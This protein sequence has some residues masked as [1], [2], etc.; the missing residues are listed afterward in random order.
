[1][2]KHPFLLITL[3]ILSTTGSVLAESMEGDRFFIV[4]S[5]NPCNGSISELGKYESCLTL[6]QF[7]S[8]F[9]SH[10]YDSIILE[11]D[12]GDHTLD[13]LLTISNI[14]SLTINSTTATVIYSRKD[15]RL[16][17]NSI[18]DITIRGITFLSCGEIEVVHINWF[19]FEN[20][21][22]QNSQ[23]GSLVLEHVLDATIKGSM[24]SQMHSCC[25]RT[26]VLN[27]HESSILVQ[28]CVFLNNVGYRSGAIHAT[29]STI[30]VNSSIF[31]N[32]TAL[33]FHISLHGSAAAIHVLNGAQKNKTVSVVNCKFS[34]NVGKRRGSIYVDGSIR[35]FNST[36]ENNTAGYRGGA[37]YSISNDNQVIISQNDFSHN[38]G[39]VLVIIG[40]NVSV[41]I[42]QNRFVSNILSRLRGGALYLSVTDGEVSITDSIFINTTS[43]KFRDMR[44]G[45]AALISIHGTSSLFISQ[46]T[47]SNNSAEQRGGALSIY[48]FDP[49]SSVSIYQSSFTGNRVRYRGG[50]VFVYI[51]FNSSMIVDFSNFI[52]NDAISNGG[53]VYI[54]TVTDNFVSFN[55]TSFVKNQ[56]IYGDAGA[57]LITGANSSILL[58]STNFINNSAGSF[59]GVLIISLTGTGSAFI[60]QSKFINNSAPNGL[61]GAMSLDIRYNVKITANLFQDNSAKHCGAVAFGFSRGAVVNSKFTH[62]SAVVGQGGAICTSIGIINFLNTNFSYNYAQDDAGVLSASGSVVKVSGSVF[63]QNKASDQGGVFYTNF[64]PSNYTISNSIFVNN[65]VGSDGGVIYVWRSG[66]RV[67]ISE[68]SFGFNNAIGS[69]G[70]ISI[71]GSNLEMIEVVLFN[72]S[73]ELGEILSTC[74]SSISI[75]NTTTELIKVTD[76]TFPNCTFFESEDPMQGITDAILPTTPE[77]VNQTITQTYGTFASQPTTIVDAEITKPT[78]SISVEVTTSSAPKSLPT[79]TT[80]YISST[81]D[82]TST[83][84]EHTNKGK[85]KNSQQ[86]QEVA[87]SVPIMCT[88]VLVLVTGFL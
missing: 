33:L 79:V 51:K 47:F 70:V 69:G 57:L 25:D 46:S 87:I 63:D 17:L 24:F 71:N 21:S 6:K 56:A 82:T 9:N 22:L 52:E 77:V 38:T 5:D 49:N 73:A 36:F 67:R 43:P 85:V 66:S 8:V 72:N 12:L 1:M 58:S 62:N 40:T 14:T 32:N 76:P 45:G 31:E 15:A 54:D 64:R 4:T 26:A 2:E 78:T 29:L 44:E 30:T 27:I 83:I 28:H 68:S 3:L 42:S 53:A 55:E 81:D 75:V 18:Q 65:Q 7:I 50:A 61:G 86:P 48:L 88:V 60:F 59:G 80:N 35:L 37:L 19:T 41:S 39:G 16:K 11:L 10:S 34:N 74:H 84:T 23:N 13:S 20:S